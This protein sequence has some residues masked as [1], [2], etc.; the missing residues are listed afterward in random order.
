MIASRWK[1]ARARRR[2]FGLVEMAITG[3][4]VAAAMA[5]TVHVVA[6]VALERRAAGRRERALAEASN[7]IER[8]AARPFDEIRPE[9]LTTAQVSEAARAYLVNPT[10]E[11]RVANFDDAPARKRIVVEIRWGDRAG[12]P[13]SPVRLVAWAYR[14]G[15][16][17]R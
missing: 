10:V 15:G 12:R 14:Q 1:T 6:W 7:L 8:I 5:A 3:L 13:E 17:D 2:G 4:L 11:A 9:S 16:P